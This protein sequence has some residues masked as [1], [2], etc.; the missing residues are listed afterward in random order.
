VKEGE[1]N[2]RGRVDGSADWS[3]RLIVAG[4]CFGVVGLA[5]FGLFAAE[6]TRYPA[7]TLAMALLVVLGLWLLLGFACEA[8]CSIAARLAVGP[9]GLSRATGR[10]RAG[11]GR[12]WRD[13]TSPADGDRLANLVATVGGLGV[14]GLTSLL[15]IEHLISTRNGPLLIALT[16]VG[17]QIVLALVA[18]YAA[19]LIRRVV[20]RLWARSVDGRSVQRW[21]NTPVVALA[22]VAVG[23]LGAAAASTMMW[24]TLVAADVLA[25][26][27]P[28]L[29][30]C[31]YPLLVETL[32]RRIARRPA[33]AIAPLLAIAALYVGAQPGPSQAVVLRESHTAK[34][35]YRFVETLSDFDNDGSATFPV[36]EDCAPFDPDIHPLAEEIAG[37][38]V[39][40]NCDGTDASD[41]PSQP[42]YPPLKK[43]I[44]PSPNFVLIT[45]DSTR[46]DHMGFMGYERDTTPNLDRIAEQSVVFERAF[47]QDSGTGPS[48][49]SL[50]AGQTPFQLELEDSHHFPPRIAKSERLLGEVLSEEGYFLEAVK[51]GR[52]FRK[53]R[54]DARRGF[55]KWKDH[56]RGSTDAKKVT[57]GAVAALERADKKQPFFLWVHYYDPHEP[58]SHHEEYDFGDDKIGRY[59]SEI[60]YA[61]EHVGELFERLESFG[62]KNDDRPLYVFF[63]S[64]HGENFG[65]HGKAPHARTLYRPVTHVPLLAWGTDIEHRR[66][67]EPVALNDLYPTILEMASIPIPEKVT[68]VSQAPILFGE[69][70]PNRDRLVFQENSYAR[71]RR[72]VKGVVTERYHFIMDLTTGVDELYDY[73]EDWD[74]QVDLIGQGLPVE[75][76][77]ERA[78][79]A[80]LNTT[81][82]PEGLRE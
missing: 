13:R 74:E 27:L 21:M 25:L 50:V 54:W 14:F 22:L 5:E 64:D 40:Q 58:Y 6:A 20:R 53:K 51:C 15:L 66:I 33:V 8:L 3:A 52:V 78:L 43:K 69:A 45:W 29:A 42:T 46:A 23:C 55:D 59:D 76:R 26:A 72:H 31:L 30:I 9:A 60:R 37:D 2:P 18:A 61:D 48:F 41:D 17:G 16:A 12:L 47:S 38:G 81:E 77:L 71:P 79:R 1:Q 28:V 24:E 70:A 56:C 63:S 35:L 39:D 19:V 49:W 68:M 67:S 82:I 65:E 32:G 80:F 73:E 11:L 75:A 4:L 7:S 36:L 57:K 62:S 34:Y 10:A 44:E